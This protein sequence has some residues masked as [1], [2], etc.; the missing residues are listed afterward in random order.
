M[1][2]EAGGGGGVKAID[3]KVL[4]DD[5]Q[6]MPESPSSLCSNHIRLSLPAVILPA[7]SVE[8]TSSCGGKES[9]LSLP[10]IHVTHGTAPHPPLESAS[11]PILLETAKPGGVEGGGSGSLPVFKVVY[12]EVCTVPSEASRLHQ[13]AI[14]SLHP[15]P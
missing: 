11:F 10:S 9:L 8:E 3:L 2:G 12:E 5:T 4:L 6:P 7:S 13:E 14:I 15:N 1:Y